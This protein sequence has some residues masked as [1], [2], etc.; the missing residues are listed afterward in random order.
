[1][2]NKS[3]LN[4]YGDSINTIC[5]CDSHKIDNVWSIRCKELSDPECSLV[6]KLFNVEVNLSI[7]I[8][9]SA[10]ANYNGIIITVR[11][12]ESVY[13]SSRYCGL[14]YCN[15]NRGNFCKEKPTVLEADE[16]A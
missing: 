14:L 8:V 16:D 12:I 2:S 10:Q 15:V 1:M 5:S 9:G 7:T 6:T 13:Y 4:W 3:T 11:Y